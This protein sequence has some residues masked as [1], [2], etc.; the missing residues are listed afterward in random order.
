MNTASTQVTITID[1]KECLVDDT[2]TILEA[3]N[4]CGISIP[5]LCHH[6]A[7]SNWGGCRLCVVQV[8]GS[9]KLAA[10]CATP[11]RKGMTVV[12]TNDRIKESRKTI[13]EFLFAE[14]N[15]NCMF[16]PQSGDC[17][18]QKLAYDLGMDHVTVPFSFQS[19]PTDVTSEHMAIDH[20]RCVLCGR[21]I[22]ACQE[23]VGANVLGFHNRGPKTMVGLDLLETRET[24]TCLG[25]G[26]C[27]QVCP[28]G[29]IYNRYRTH[30]AVKGH[31]AERKVSESFCPMC[32]LLCPTT[33][34][35][36]EGQLI[37][38]EGLLP[39]NGDR[40]D[41]GQLCS[42]GR[43]D[44]LK[45]VGG[46]LLHPMQRNPDGSWSGIGWEEA[47]SMLAS[48]LAEIKSR[49]GGEALFGWTSSMAS[50]EELML[51]KELMQKG[52]SAVSIDTFDG[53]HY[54]NVVQALQKGGTTY[55]ERSWKE[56]AAAD[57]VLM[58]GGDPSDSQ[59]LL[60]SLIRKRQ[61][62]QGVTVAVIGRHGCPLPLGAY[63]ITP[64]EGRLSDVVRAL[65]MAVR[66]AI[67]RGSDT[68][69]GARE[70]KGGTVEPLLFRSGLGEPERKIFENVVAAY[71]AARNPMILVATAL[72]GLESGDPLKDVRDMAVLKS[73]PEAGA[74]N[75]IILKP[76][77]NSAGAWRLGIAGADPA[78]PKERL[79]GGVIRLAGAEDEALESVSGL[80]SLEFLAVFSPY[81]PEKLG[82]TAN[83][84]IPV[85]A[86]METD[87]SYMSLDGRDWAYRSATLDPP[88]DVR[89]MWQILCELMERCASPSAA[90]TWDDIRERA[91]RAL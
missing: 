27:L 45:D 37:K 14:R 44:V 61:R 86:W 13:L 51:F 26:A 17:E 55:M 42:R 47:L 9:P 4:Q 76:A 66:E 1:G 48:R 16:C 46:R 71:V 83:L 77:G 82:Q 57:V 20:N 67:S 78:V 25:C 40:P 15:H 52:W 90:H 21:C 32:G 23:I 50:N 43:F 91:K 12:T 53:H 56:I 11:V 64:E 49:E 18:L 34:Y 69:K 79:R 41:R 70:P 8:D 31:S 73:D 39:S 60:S 28:T 38:V 33:A 22:R 89:P 65:S 30:Y 80:D 58:I 7:L 35:T 87:G 54:R 88:E 5:T 85:A 62:E 2:L 3:A 59:P 81:V 84:L 10:S 75:L 74:L 24:S 68:E 6:P 29:A 63:Q 36:R 72:T 19:F